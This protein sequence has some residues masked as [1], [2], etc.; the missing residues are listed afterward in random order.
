MSSSLRHPTVWPEVGGSRCG[1]RLAELEVRFELSALNERVAELHASLER[2]PQSFG[3]GIRSRIADALDLG[4]EIGA[5]EVQTAV[6]AG[7][8]PV[9]VYLFR[10]VSR[11]LDEL[12]AAAV[13]A[14][15]FDGSEINGHESSPNVEKGCVRTPDST[16]R[17]DS[18]RGGE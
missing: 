16:L 9:M 18:S 6:G 7:G 4:V 11:L 14:K 17:G 12:T 3:D 13:R 15:Q 5:A 1:C 2:L 10:P 8:S